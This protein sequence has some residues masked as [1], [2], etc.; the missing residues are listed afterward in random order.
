MKYVNKLL[1]LL[2]IVFSRSFAISTDECI[3]QLG[4]EQEF[5][6]EQY[7]GAFLM[8]AEA[9]EDLV[10]SA[11]YALEKIAKPVR[12]YIKSN[13]DRIINNPY[14]DTIAHV[15]HGCNLSD[16]EMAFR[17][18]R[19]EHVKKAQQKLF[20]M[21]LDDEDVLEIAFSCSG[22]GWRSMICS[23][24]F[25][26][27][28]HKLGLLD[29]A[30]YIS[31]LSGSTWFVAPWISSE[32]DIL[33]YRTLADKKIAEGL[34]T[35]TIGN[36]L[37]FFAP[38][39]TKFAFNH[40]I[41]VIDIYGALLG[42]NLLADLND[43]PS[44]VYLS[45]QQEIIADGKYPMPLYS[46][47]YGGYNKK[48]Y[49]FEFTPFECGSCE[50]N[51]HIPSWSIGRKFKNGKS[52]RCEPEESF[53]FLLGAFGSAFSAKFTKIYKNAMKFFDLPDY[54]EDLPFAAVFLDAVKGC[55]QALIETDI[56]QLRFTSAKIHNF[57][58]KL[59]DSPLKYQSHLKLIDA[60]LDFNNPV[61]LTY[62]NKVLKQ[63]PDVIFIFDSSANSGKEQLQKLQKYAKKHDL[64]LPCMSYDNVDKKSLT[65]FQDENDLSV[66]M[67]LYMPRVNDQELLSYYKNNNELMDYVE[68]LQDFDI[69]EA[70]HGGFAGT[71]SF[72][73]SKQQVE[74]L[75]AMTDFNCIANEQLIKQALKKRVEKK[76][77]LK[78]K[79]YL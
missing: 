56:G 11:E 24:G 50:L 14:K 43:K 52:K 72:N 19:F 29:T 40:H 32:K 79:R 9:L 5:D 73:Y 47:I 71:F 53:G 21:D 13:Q 49:W 66:P 64:K 33:S 35:P 7:K 78:N 38:V 8:F 6:Q 41:N 55:L 26:M 10:G 15:R 1:L 61:F 46:A 27:G 75:L 39:W 57:M 77:E 22:G 36:F 59:K 3:S 31:S 54:L 70:V 76:R 44:E 69:E 30:M 74:K 17:K 2:F 18:K 37:A 20:E 48:N 4:Y 67:I 28:A 25:C 65:I 16:G 42:N 45:E 68:L 58:Y 51:Y 60:G 62:R 12:D 63:A 23:M 34:A